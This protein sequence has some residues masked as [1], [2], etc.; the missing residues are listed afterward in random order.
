[1]AVVLLVAAAT[2]VAARPRDR[3]IT[4]AAGL[5]LAGLMLAYLA[6]R[7]TGI[8]W[9]DPEVE[10]FDAVGIVT[11]LVEALGVVVALWQINPLGHQV[12]PTELQEVSR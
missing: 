1:M 3:R 5:L 8:P 2:A 6:T 10:A 4:S 12:R 11:N 7:T 9:L